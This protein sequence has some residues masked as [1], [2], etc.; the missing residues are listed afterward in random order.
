M[1][2]DSPCGDH[3]PPFSEMFYRPLERQCSPLD[4]SLPCSFT[5]SRWCF[6]T[7]F[8]SSFVV[9]SFLYF[10]F[11]FFQLS[12]RFSSFVYFSFN[13][14]LFVYWLYVLFCMV[15]LCMALLPLLVRSSLLGP[16]CRVL[17]FIL[18][19]NYIIIY[20]QKKIFQN[21]EGRRDGSARNYM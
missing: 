8:C 10:Y 12:Y 21:V 7:I 20:G 9:H 18:A 11:F 19:L 4:S 3:P 16:A 6:M 17:L 14:C 1:L 13:Y 2:G 15:P 5:F